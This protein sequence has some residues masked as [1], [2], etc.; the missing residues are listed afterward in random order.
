MF[1]HLWQIYSGR[2]G[3]GGTDLPFNIWG[4][5]SLTI[6]QASV[7]TNEFLSLEAWRGHRSPPQTL[8][9]A[10]KTRRPP[11]ENRVK[12]NV[13]AAFSTEKNIA[14]LAA[15]IR[16]HK[17]NLVT[18]LVW[19]VPC[20]SSR[21]AEALALWERLLLARNCLC[22]NPIIESDNLQLAEACRNGDLLYDAA[23]VIND[24]IKLKDSFSGSACALVWASG[25]SNKIA[26]YVAKSALV[27]NLPKDW[28]VRR[29]YA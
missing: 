22:E 24:I 19:R 1:W 21:L 9:Q 25:Y 23:M 15:I 27:G 13:D 14:S 2:Y 4:R 10:W 8:K 29:P 12:C 7:L 28:L 26:H 20:S 18:G 3:R 16:D 11:P 5:P 6:N 17:G